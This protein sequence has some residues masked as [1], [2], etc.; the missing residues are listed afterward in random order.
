MLVTGLGS[1]TLAAYTRQPNPFIGDE[2]RGRDE[3]TRNVIQ[4]NNSDNNN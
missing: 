1:T 2:K 4:K 3:L